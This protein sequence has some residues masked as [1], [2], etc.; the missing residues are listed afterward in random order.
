MNLIIIA[1]LAALL[2]VGTGA[3]TVRTHAGTAAGAVAPVAAATPSPTDPP[4][5]MDIQPGGG[6][7]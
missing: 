3:A 5:G 1:A 7:S 6:P 2:S 4:V